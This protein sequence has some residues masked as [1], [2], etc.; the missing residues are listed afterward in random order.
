MRL[1]IYG[2]GAIGGTLAARL[3]LAGRA[4]TL[5]ARGAQADA[6]RAAGLRFRPTPEQPPVVLRLPV[7]ARAA[8]AGPQDLIITAVKAHALPAIAEDIA[9]ALAPGGAALFAV[10]GVPWWYC[11]GLGGA[12]EGARVAAV[13]PQGVLARHVGAARTIGAALF[14]AATQEGPGIVAQHAAGRMVI[15]APDG[16][17]TA[18]LAAIADALDDPA[19]R[20]ETSAR[21]RDHVATKFAGNVATNPLSAL[22][23]APIGR[24]YADA[25]LAAFG[26]CAMRE[27]VAVATAL[28]AR[29][30]IDVDARL[31]QYRFGALAAFRPSTLQ[32]IDLGRPLEIDALIGAIAE[33]G[34][35]AGVPT[36][37]ID[38]LHAM[39]RTLADSLGLSPRP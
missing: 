20:V 8:A 22:L 18:A 10:N 6:L 9:A 14:F 34:D 28:G 5:V 37:A 12:H 16:A 33:L 15:G 27:A 36:P 38:L 13:D 39:L 4:V 1:C 11:H 3:A 31:R 2:A 17:M 25:E 23:R 24:V 30:D 19:I 26:A 7:V 35:R 21:I 29:V 32:D